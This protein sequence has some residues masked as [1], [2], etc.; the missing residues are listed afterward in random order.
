MPSKGVKPQY[1]P[2]HKTKCLTGVE[3]AKIYE[4][5]KQDELIDP[6]AIKRELGAEKPMVEDYQ[7]NNSPQTVNKKPF[8]DVQEWSILSDLLKYPS[9]VITDYSSVQIIP[10]KEQKTIQKDVKI[11]SSKC[12]HEFLPT[13]PKI[14][15]HG[16]IHRIRYN[17]FLATLMKL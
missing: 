1:V 3:A 17:S 13:S 16:C 7:E 10:N 5:I 15:I 12:I 14:P 8:E 4:K 6:L 11:K 9:Q 2:N